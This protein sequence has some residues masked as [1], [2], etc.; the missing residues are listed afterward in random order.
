M[1]DAIKRGSQDWWTWVAMLHVA[2]QERRKIKLSPTSPVT[3]DIASC[4]QFIDSINHNPLKKLWFLVS[5]GGI[6]S[7]E[8][9]KLGNH[10]VIKGEDGQTY[11]MKRKE[12]DA[13]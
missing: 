10:V 13:K 8:R 12:K 9:K 2:K 1:G 5:N 6:H 4:N 7:A 3:V 11:N